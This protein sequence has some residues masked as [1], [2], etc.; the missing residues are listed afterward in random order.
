MTMRLQT[1]WSETAICHLQRLYRGA[2]G[3]IILCA[4]SFEPEVTQVTA[5]RGSIGDAE[6][7]G[8]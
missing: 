2:R 5:K 4:K 7:K 8:G 6:I 3:Q 1:V